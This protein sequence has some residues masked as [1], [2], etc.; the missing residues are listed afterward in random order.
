MKTDNPTYYR[1]E[2]TCGR[3]NQTTHAAICYNLITGVSYFFE[4]SSADVMGILLSIP[5]NGRISIEVLSNETNISE[6]SLIPFANELCLL[7]L[8]TDIPI[9]KEYIAD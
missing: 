9:E 6:K 5:K 7:G 3:Y 2:W 4:D 8:L 1:P